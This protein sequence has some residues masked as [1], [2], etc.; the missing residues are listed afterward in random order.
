MQRQVEVVDDP[1]PRD[2]ELAQHARSLAVAADIVAVRARPLVRLPGQAEL[3]AHEREE[4]GSVV[5]PHQAGRPR[6]RPDPHVEPTGS[7]ML[8]RPSA[9]STPLSSPDHL[10]LR[11]GS[12]A[13]STN[14]RSN[15]M[16]A[17]IGV[18]T[19]ESTPGLTIGPRAEKEYAVEPVG[20]AT[21]T[22]SAE[23]VVT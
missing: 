3:L 10:E 16:C 15:T 20:D 23:N 8:R 6:R 13:S 4:A 22:P 14:D 17:A 19:S 9:E 1:Q 18:S 7:S 11:P 5:A 2:V 21:I 12:S